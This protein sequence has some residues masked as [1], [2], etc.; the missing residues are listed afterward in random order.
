MVRSSV[1]K[2]D[3]RVFKHLQAI[4]G[5]CD[6]AVAGISRKAAPSSAALKHL[7]L[8][9]RTSWNAAIRPRRW[10]PGEQLMVKYTAICFEFN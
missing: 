8:R 7:V 6:F 9:A 5:L 4:D 3:C 2:E 10:P 1:L